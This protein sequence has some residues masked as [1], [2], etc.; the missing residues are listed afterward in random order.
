MVK[1]QQFKEGSIVKVPLKEERWV[2]GRLLPAHQIGIYDVIVT[3]NKEH[4]SFLANNSII[5]RPYLFVVSIY[6]DTVTS[7]MFEVVG[8]AE[9][10]AENVKSLPPVFTQDKMDL[11]KCTLYYT[12]GRVVD[13]SPQDCIGLEKFSKWT[14]QAVVK[15]IEDHY[16]GKKNILVENFKVKL[17]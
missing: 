1:K 14:G 4:D 15:R 5:S 10:T 17:T 3:N 11:H 12:D 8:F 13:A 16:E 2:L 7:G 9:L 6:T